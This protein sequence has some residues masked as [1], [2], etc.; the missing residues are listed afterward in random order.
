MECT[1]SGDVPTVKEA[2]TSSCTT[3]AGPDVCASD[4][5]ACTKAG[6]VCS[7]T[8]PASCGYKSETV[9]SCSGDKTLPVEKAPCKSSTV[10]LTTASGPTCTPAD[11]IC[12]DDG[13]HCGSTF[14][15]DC[16]LQNNTLYKCTNGA[17]PLATK[18]CAPGI[19][20][21]NVIKGTGE[22]RA[23]ADDKCIDQC[24]CKEENVPICASAFDPVCNYDNKTLMTC[25]NVGGV[26]T[27]KETCT[28]SCTMQPGPDVC[29]FN[30]CTCT[31]VGDACGESFPS[32]CGLDKDTVYSCAAD[33][34]LP[35]KKIAC[36]E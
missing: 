10:C 33:K 19:C 9:Y 24:A 28:L 3:Q 1:S 27:V 13:S 34:A 25:G 36:D 14:V 12:K 5:C 2:C 20:S 29:T 35:Q 7:Q 31:K 15:E 30:P 8:F 6:D 16:G 26:P 23:S 11:C 17:L 4:A 32:T 22:F 21:A 18:D